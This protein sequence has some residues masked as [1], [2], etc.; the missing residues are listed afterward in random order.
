MAEIGV[1]LKQRAG[2]GIVIVEGEKLT[3]IP[4]CL[5]KVYGKVTVNVSTVQQ[6]VR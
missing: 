2:M 6:W 5:L 4:K 1:W 3:C